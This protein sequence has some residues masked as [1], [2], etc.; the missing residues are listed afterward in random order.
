MDRLE[1]LREVAGADERE[2]VGAVIGRYVKTSDETPFVLGRRR[3]RGGHCEWT[4]M[5]VLVAE[6][7][8]PTMV[9][10]GLAGGRVTTGLFP[11]PICSFAVG[12]SRR[13]IWCRIEV[14]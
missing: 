3:D 11:V 5:F 7:N 4:A 6:K 9:G 2:S 8:C 1:L 14:S 10:V 12:Q 13:G